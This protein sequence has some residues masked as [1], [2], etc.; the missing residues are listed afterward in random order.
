MCPRCTQLEDRIAELEEALG[1]RLEIAP[2]WN[3]TPM[4]SRT[5]ALLLKRPLV[6]PDMIELI[7]RHAMRKGEVYSDHYP[8]VVICKLRRK[9]RAHNIVIKTQYS[10]GFELDAENRNRA[11]ELNDAWLQRYKQ[12]A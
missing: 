7:Q 9:L 6:R 12:A 5:F 10:V 11:R 8:S 1:V 4:E 3:L 2:Q